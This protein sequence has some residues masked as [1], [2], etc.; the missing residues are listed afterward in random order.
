MRAD[1]R[2]RITWLG[3]ATFRVVASNGTAILLDPWIAGNP[4]CP[5]TLE[6]VGQVDIVCVTHG[7]DDHFSDS[8]EIVRRTKAALISSPEICHYAERHGVAYRTESLP[9]NI[10]G[11]VDFRGLSFHATHAVHA[12]AIYGVEWRD[13]KLMF[14]NGTAMGF[15]IEDPAG[16][17][18]YYAG[19]TGLT[20]DMQVVGLMYR[21]HVAILPI[22][23]RFTMTPELAA[24]AAV[25]TG[26]PTVIP[27]HYNTFDFNRQEPIRL[28]QLIDEKRAGIRVVALRPGETFEYDIASKGTRPA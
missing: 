6:H 28:Q 5:I 17:R 9:L 22:G 13:Q 7:H 25:W 26:A 23:G 2:L 8:L 3:H 24:M 16:P 11:R 12:S 1:L 20:M 27:M 10:G 21:P 4:A 19:D 18:I 14:P 15:V